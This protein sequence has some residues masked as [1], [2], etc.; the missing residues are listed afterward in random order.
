VLGGAPAAAVVFSR[1]V[2]ARTT[3]D[4]RVAELESRL[5]SVSGVERAR[6][7]TELAEVRTA[8]RSEKLG[9]VA[10]EFD[11]VHSIQRAVTVGSV[12]AVIAP[13]EIRPR[14]IAALEEGLQG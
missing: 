4:P 6:L 3:A 11:S 9:Q 7:A 12:D 8:V 10:A 5:A 1:D 2:D 14:I 13:Q